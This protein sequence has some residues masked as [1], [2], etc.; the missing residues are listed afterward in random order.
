[1]NIL[2]SFLLMLTAPY[3]ERV[4][5]EN[6]HF[7]VYQD[8]KKI[9]TENFSITP[10]GT[11]FTAQGNIR[12]SMNNQTVELRSRMELD[13][14]LRPTYYEV[15]SKGNLIKL[16]VEQPLSELEYVVQGKS[17][18]HDVRFPADGVI[19]DDNFFHHY[20]ILL[21]RANLDGASLPTFV[22]Q[23]NTLGLLSVRAG[24]NRTYELETAN[25]KLVATTDADGRLLRLSVPDAKVVVER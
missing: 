24:A 10:R 16:K 5:L 9:G 22:P 12:I 11:G 3:L 1:M 15:E 18:P 2:L 19:L 21:Y 8:G 7:N 13:A 17:Q 20:L 14:Q 23:Q 25:L 4:K 6:S